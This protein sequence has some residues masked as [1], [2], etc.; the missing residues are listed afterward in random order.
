MLL[1]HSSGLPRELLGFDGRDLELEIRIKENQLL[2]F[3][4]NEEIALLKAES[5]NVFFADPHEPES[6][7]F[8]TNE[9]GTYD[10]LM[11]WKGIKLK[12]IR[13]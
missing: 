9:T 11:G 1:N 13:K 3:Q 8:V 7:E 10:L 5:A 6:F 2:V 4:D 12:G